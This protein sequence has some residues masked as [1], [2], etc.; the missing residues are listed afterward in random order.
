MHAVASVTIPAGSTTAPFTVTTA[1]VSAV[2]Y[3]TIKAVA[4]GV[5]KDR[6]ADGEPMRACDPL[7]LFLGR[8]GPN[9]GSH[10]SP[11]QFMEYV[12]GNLAREVAWLTGWT[13]R[14]WLGAMSRS[15]PAKRRRQVVRLIYVLSHDI[16]ERLPRSSMSSKRQFG[17]HCAKPTPNL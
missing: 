17:R 5:T 1:D 2:S 10:L 3:A 4:G 8:A 14:I 9:W 7:P 12:S 11:G 15:R 13:D 6:E 16:K